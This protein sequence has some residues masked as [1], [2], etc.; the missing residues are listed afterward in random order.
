MS[1]HVKTYLT[2]CQNQDAITCSLR[3]AFHE[4]YQ[5]VGDIGDVLQRHGAR[6]LFSFRACAVALLPRSNI[7]NVPYVLAPHAVFLEKAG[8]LRILG[9][10]NGEGAPALL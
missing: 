1:Y 2:H 3:Q 7:P 4:V 10:R 9:C 5:D 6:G 8:E